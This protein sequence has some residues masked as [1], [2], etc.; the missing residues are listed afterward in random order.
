MALA[1]T[2]SFYEWLRVIFSFL[3]FVLLAKGMS[4]L[5]DMSAVGKDGKA[6]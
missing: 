2:P 5:G 6:W 3:P 4:D 1:F